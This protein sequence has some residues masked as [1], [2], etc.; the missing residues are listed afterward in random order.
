MFSR[1]EARLR[2]LALSQVLKKP[3]VGIKFVF[4]PKLFYSYL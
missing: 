2:K 3:S 4:F 1:I